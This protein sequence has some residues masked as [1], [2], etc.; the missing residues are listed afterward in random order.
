MQNRTL[1][2][3]WQNQQ[4]RQ[5]Y[6][7]ANLTL[8]E[9][10]DYRFAYESQNKKRGLKDALENG[11]HLHPS[12]PSAV[13]TYTSD[14][15]FS[16][17]SRRLPNKARPDYV[18]LLK[19]N[20]LSVKNDEFEVLTMTGGK[21][22]SDNYE[23]V[24]PVD[25]DGK[26]FSFDFYVRGWQ[27]YNEDKRQ[28]KDLSEISFETEEDNGQDPDAIIV[29]YAGETIGYVPAF[30]SDFMKTVIESNSRFEV[31]SF[32]FNSQASSHRKV[33]ILVKGQKANIQKTERE[34]N[35]LLTV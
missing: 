35:L 12:F 32:D 17:F 31:V 21:L 2:L 14:K 22:I 29:K 19:A 11:Y 16:A 24:K 10:D 34:T 5:W 30:Y 9:N 8:E 7:V 3:L 33:N 18:E 27:H 1:C 25:F 26:D 15:L 6:H 13:K 23:F 20:N 4:S 28:L